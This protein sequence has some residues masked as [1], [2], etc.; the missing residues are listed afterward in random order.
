MPIKQIDEVDPE[1]YANF[2]V[3]AEEEI[4]GAFSEFLKEHARTYKDELYSNTYVYED[5]GVVKGYI[6]LC[7]GSVA[8]H[9]VSGSQK[10]RPRTEIKSS[11]Y[12]AVLVGKLAVDKKYR[13][14]GIGEQL[15]KHAFQVHRSIIEQ[16]GARYMIIHAIPDVVGY[17]EKKFSFDKI[18]YN[19]RG[20]TWTMGLDFFHYANWYRRR[21]EEGLIE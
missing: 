7:A 15:M 13:N 20:K 12:P 8:R 5:E 1:R 10:K 3:G 9:I 6:A 14:R 4:A 2:E 19:E 21:Q 11:Q 16:I 17:Y 18:K